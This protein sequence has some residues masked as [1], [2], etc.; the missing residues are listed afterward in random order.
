MQAPL[1]TEV[2]HWSVG[3]EFSEEELRVVADGVLRH[4]RSVAAAGQATPIACLLRQESEIVAG[5]A[6]RTEFGRL[7]VEY[8]WVAEGYR[9]QGLGTE[10]LARLEEAARDRGCR[11]AVIETL[12]D[13]VAGLY[14]RQGY[15]QLAYIPGYVGPFNRSI[16]LKRLGDGESL[17]VRAAGPAGRT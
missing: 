4:G 9:Q 8:L 15:E 6:G 13:R 1:E 14:R 2:L 11:D 17:T 3:Y 12:D 5:A 7:F 16:L 10:A